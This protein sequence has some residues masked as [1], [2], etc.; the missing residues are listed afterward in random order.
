MNRVVD[1][2]DAAQQAR[3][4]PWVE[5]ECYQLSS[6]RHVAQMQ[7]LDFGGPKIVR[8]RQT[9]A[10]QKLGFA[11]AD[12]CTVS[13]SSAGE[14]TRF[15]E[16]LSVEGDTVFF[17]P[18]NVEYDIHVPAGVETS[19]VGFSW[20]A[21]L[22][23]A[24]ALNP[25]M[26]ESPPQGVVALP[27]PMHREFKTI[28]DLWLSAA[29]AHHLPGH[30]PDAAR[31]QNHLLHAVLQIAATSENDTVLSF[32]ERRRALQIGRNARTFVDDRFDADMLP[33]VVDICMALGV[34]E[35]TLQYAFREYVGMSPVAYLRVCRLNRVR[36]ELVS[37]DPASTTVTQVA[38]RF[39]FFHLGRFAGDYR[40]LFGA[41]PSETLAS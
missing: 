16:H 1:I 31:L 33:T 8:E 36:V 21:F 3:L 6:G 27:T 15:S 20:Q 9:A 22:Q 17:M 25:A 7:S 35:R 28:V 39:G 37:A 38:M 5:M 32:G 4:Q 40:R 41:T 34:S 10:V 26:W 12:F 30:P 18:G 24:R 14:A 19:Y 11:P 13:M 29:D 2:E 23:A